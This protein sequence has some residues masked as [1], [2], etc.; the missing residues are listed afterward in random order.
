MGK[1]IIFVAGLLA[2][3]KTTF[4]EYLSTH[5]NMLLINKDYVKEILCDTIG[6]ANREENLK[7]SDA[8]HQ[9]MRYIAGNSMKIGLPIILESNFNPHDAAYFEEEV[10]KYNYKPITVILTGDKNIFYDRFVK[11]WETRHPGHKSFD[12]FTREEFCKQQE[13]WERFPISG[14]RIIVDTTRFEDIE[15]DEVISRIK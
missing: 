14:E 8:T 13:G 11:R 4:S 9:L 12:L 7:L 5:L 6:F 15:Y 2:S 1:Y 10:Q 3:G